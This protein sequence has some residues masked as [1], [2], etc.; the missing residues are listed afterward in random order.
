LRDRL[1]RAPVG[2]A[3]TLVDGTLP[4]PQAPGLGIELDMAEVEKWTA[5]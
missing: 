1:T 3:E 5:R 4:V 2:A